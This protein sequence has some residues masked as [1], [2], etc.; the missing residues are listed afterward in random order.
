MDT[1][2]WAGSLSSLTGASRTCLCLPVVLLLVQKPIPAIAVPA[3][4][5]LDP[6]EEVQLQR[7]LPS[8]AELFAV[9]RELHLRV[10]ICLPEL[11]IVMFYTA[12]PYLQLQSEGAATPLQLFSCFQRHLSA[13]VPVWTCA[14]WMLA[15]VCTLC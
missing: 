14:L 1:C 7:G 8:F 10:K 2:W 6:A 3:P 5:L 9:L 13:G 15:C 4:Q 12:H 11:I